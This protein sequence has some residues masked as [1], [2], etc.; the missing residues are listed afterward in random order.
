MIDEFMALLKNNTW[1]IVS[2][3][4]QRKLIECKWVFRVKEN[5]DDS[6]QK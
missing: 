2:L 4:H 5:H 6:I 3:P 1:S